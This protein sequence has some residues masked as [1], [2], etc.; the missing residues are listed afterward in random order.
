MPDQLFE[1]NSQPGVRRDGTQLDSPYYNDGVWVRWQRQRPKK[2]GGYRMMSQL[3]NGPIRSMLVD[4]RNGI[5]SVHSFS[6]WG[7][8][9]LQFNTSGAG[10]NLD[11]RTPAN[12]VA[13]ARNTWTH[14]TLFSGIG[15]PYTALLAAS[16]PDLTTIDS[17]EL[18]NVWYGNV[19]DSSAMAQM[20]ANFNGVAAGPLMVSGGITVL[21]PFAVVFGSN[22]LI[23]NSKENDFSPTGWDPFVAGTFANE[24]NV[25]GTKFVAGAPVRGGSQ[26][27]AGLFWAL[28]AL[29]RMSFVGGAAGWQY[30]TLS[31][32]T[33]I[34]SKKGIVEH[35]GKFFWPGTDRFLFYNGVVQ[36]LP[37]Q[38]NSN[39]FFENINFE[40]RN[41]VWGTKIPRWGEI[42]WF[43]PRGAAT[44]CDH[45]VI[46]NYLENTWYDAKK[47][48]SAGG[49]VQL[50]PFPIWGGRE[51]RFDS[52][53]LTIGFIRYTS[54]QVAAG[55][56]S[57]PFAATTG[58]VDGMV[59]VGPGIPPGAK[60]ASHTTTAVVLT[61]ATTA[62]VFAGTPITFSTMT[63][64]FLRSDMVT[65]VSSGAFGT[66]VRAD[67]IHLNVDKVT[68]K[69]NTDG[70]GNV[71]PTES[72]TGPHGAVATSMQAPYVQEVDSIYQ[73]ETGVNKIFNQ[74]VIAIEASFTSKDF[75]FATGQPFA[76]SPTT[77]DVT[78]RVVRIE[79]DFNQ[80]GPLLMTIQGRSFPKDDFAEVASVDISQESKFEDIRDAQSR[81]LRIKITTNSRNG[82]FEQG[83]VMLT[84]QPGDERSEEIT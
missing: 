24:A 74:E 41:K 68:G 27:P 21:Q 35:D 78:T 32:P 3:A 15:A 81:L 6:A 40:N 33:S 64:P 57:L 67:Y 25:A 44:E 9:R 56:T 49:Q 17:D 38:M 46:F 1:L 62:I 18:G 20:T 22:G 76:E 28:D 71:I 19:T 34:L 65:G 26:A 29:V 14:A 50:F 54:A 48:R 59:V 72:L 13:D 55:V 51:D 83:K 43:Y 66:V 31:Q 16:T 42:W 69:F 53:V 37:N 82:D 5:N 2:I 63:S 52:T 10:G 45:A 30:D 47:E 58:V 75:G 7:I 36:E 23:K 11:D 79:P 8:Q 73:H 70:L 4:S 12:Y 84:L 77:N 61:A 39:W 80:V 60:V